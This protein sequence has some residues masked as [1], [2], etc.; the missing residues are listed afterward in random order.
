MMQFV[1]QLMGAL[2]IKDS[3]H[4]IDG[5]VSVAV[6][7]EG[8]SIV[9]I[10]EHLLHPHAITEV[11]AA[12][13]VQGFLAYFE[14]FQ[15]EHTVIFA[16]EIDGCYQAVFDYSAPDQP[17]WGKHVLTY[18]PR[19]S[20]PWRTWTG[21]NKQKMD[22]W[23]FAEFIEANLEDIVGDSAKLLE[24][25]TTLVAKRDL[26]FRSSIRLSDGQTQFTYDESINGTSSH[27][28][29]AIPDS[30]TLGI[31]PYVNGEPFELKC[32]FRFRIKEGALI[33]W[34]E[35]DRPEIFR[36]KTAEKLTQQIDEQTTAV[37]IRG[38]RPASSRRS[39]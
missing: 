21:N 30:F 39:G 13:D 18:T 33:M 6:L 20:D 9:S 14:R 1:K 16:N 15:T 8:A 28:E 34:Y 27:G 2:A 10:E 25:I 3:I 38:A 17:E 4:G 37:V 23:A 24:I 29:V 11:I 12:H 26:N 22:Q 35:M 31:N 7:P 19:Q 32:R 36:K 5:G